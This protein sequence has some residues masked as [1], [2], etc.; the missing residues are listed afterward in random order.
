MH[1]IYFGLVAC[2]LRHYFQAENWTY[3]I[4]MFL[5]RKMSA[6]ALL[7]LMISTFLKDQI[8]HPSPQ[9]KSV[10]SQS[11]DILTGKKSLF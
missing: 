4:R 10:N 11:A 1:Q 7:D 8:V 9:L 6:H 5:N 2:E 3:D